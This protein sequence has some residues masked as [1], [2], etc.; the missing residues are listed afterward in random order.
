MMQ[1]TEPLLLLCMIGT[2]FVSGCMSM[3]II[4]DFKPEADPEL[5]SPAGMFYIADLKYSSHPDGMDNTS[6]AAHEKKVTRLLLPMLRKEC[7]VR[8]P[9]L[10]VDDSTTP[11]TLWSGSN[12]A[13]S[14]A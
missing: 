1:R 9:A 3:R 6:G 10:F 5:K 2:L 14:P 8:Y 4:T 13:K 7:A 11:G 12:H